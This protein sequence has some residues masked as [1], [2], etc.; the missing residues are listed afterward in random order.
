MNRMSKP[1]NSLT[2]RRFSKSSYPS[3][4][5]YRASRRR[6]LAHDRAQLFEALLDALVVLC[7]RLGAAVPA[8]VKF[9]HQRVEVVVNSI[10]ILSTEESKIVA[11]RPRPVELYQP[12][13][14]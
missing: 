14:V 4:R 8:P 3:C 9:E 1:P 12:A 2:P 11:V 7:C 6:R 10:E 5:N 13:F